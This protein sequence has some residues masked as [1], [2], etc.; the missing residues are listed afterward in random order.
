MKHLSVGSSQPED[1]LEEIRGVRGTMATPREL[2]SSH[3][4]GITEQRTQTCLTN[5]AATCRGFLLREIA[6]QLHIPEKLVRRAALANTQRIVQTCFEG[7]DRG[8]VPQTEGT[9][10]D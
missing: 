1:S 9:K 4:A 2:L 7:R 5:L 8:L 3:Q 10:N 6:Q